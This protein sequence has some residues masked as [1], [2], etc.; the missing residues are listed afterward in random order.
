MSKRVFV[1]AKIR[2]HSK[3][4]FF[5]LSLLFMREV[6]ANLLQGYENT[7]EERNFSSSWRTAMP[8]Q[9]NCDVNCTQSEEDKHVC[10]II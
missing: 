2:T 4:L 10:G 5:V 8:L 9:L 3:I 1:L 6:I 7:I